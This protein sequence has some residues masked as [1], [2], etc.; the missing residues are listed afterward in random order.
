MGTTPA[1]SASQQ[2][3]LP[4]TEQICCTVGTC[5]SQRCLRNGYLPTVNCRSSGD[6]RNSEKR[7]VIGRN[8]PPPLLL[9]T[10]FG[11]RHSWQSTGLSLR[12][13]CRSREYSPSGGNP[14]QPWGC[15]Y[16]LLLPHAGKQAFHM[17]T[18]KNPQQNCWGFPACSVTPTG[19][20]PVTF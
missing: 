8:G 15:A 7:G 6:N 2:G 14:A 16:F 10:G 20:K 13:S 17:G 12:H 1:Q 18:I 3:I 19:F 9:E 11:L 5:H 4:T